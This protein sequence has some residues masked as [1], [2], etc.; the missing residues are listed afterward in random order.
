ML[1]L[2]HPSFYSMSYRHESLWKNELP[3]LQVADY[4][5]NDALLQYSWVMRYARAFLDANLKQDAEARKFLESTPRANGIPDHMMSI[6]L[7]PAAQ[8]NP[9]PP[10][11]PA[12]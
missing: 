10:D 8:P 6:K 7:R 1:G 4:D 2:F 3:N 12:P 5:R 11:T 9:K